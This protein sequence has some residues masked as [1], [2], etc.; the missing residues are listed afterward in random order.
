MKYRAAELLFLGTGAADWLKAQPSGE[1]RGYS[2]ILIDGHILIDCNTSTLIKMKE[3]GIDWAEVSDIFITH[4]H[5]D[6]FDRGSIVKIAKA[7][8]E[9]CKSS[10]IVHAESSWASFLKSDESDEF[11]VNPLNIGERVEAGNYNILPLESNHMGSYEGEITL[12]YLFN[13]ENLCWLYATDGAWILNRTWQI[14]KEN[15][16]DAWI[17]DC[18]IGDDREGDYRIFEH[19]SLPM[20][21]M[22]SETLFKQGVLKKDATII[23]T[24]MARTLHPSQEELD[25][26]V[27]SPFKVAYDGFVHIIG[28]R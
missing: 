23:L 22:M 25:C 27:T 3:L 11:V 24:H 18:T 17:V 9:S 5:D 10:L 7:R 8:K 15:R 16:L 20:V 1:F 13:N 19:N 6:H 14:I 12:H 26:I 21:R 2:S 4:S 28:D